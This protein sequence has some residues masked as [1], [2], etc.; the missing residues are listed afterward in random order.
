MSKLGHSM[1]P[2]Y[3]ALTPLKGPHP[4]GQQLAGMAFA[5]PCPLVRLCVVMQMVVPTEH[6][7]RHLL[8]AFAA[9]MPACTL[10]LGTEIQQTDTLCNS[11]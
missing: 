10:K 4:G 6:T 11:Y 3:P 8:L 7:C 5:L 1:Q 2:M 9:V